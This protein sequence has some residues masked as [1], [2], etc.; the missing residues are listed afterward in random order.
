MSN[1]SSGDINSLNTSK[2]DDFT[3]SINI[4]DGYSWSGWTNSTS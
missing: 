2:G 3:C 4:W 1:T